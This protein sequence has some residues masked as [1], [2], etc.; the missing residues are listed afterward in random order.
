MTLPLSPT[1]NRAVRDASALYLVLAYISEFCC[2]NTLIWIVSVAMPRLKFC[3][4]SP[5]AAANNQVTFPVN[6]AL[7]LLTFYLG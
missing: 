1:A 2:E 6:T 7:V 5:K 3:T 4:Y